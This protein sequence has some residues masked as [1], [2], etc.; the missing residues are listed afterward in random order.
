M[1]G[2]EELKNIGEQVLWEGALPVRF[3]EH[4]KIANYSSRSQIICYCY[5]SAS[6][7]LIGKEALYDK[8]I[9]KKFK[10]NFLIWKL[11]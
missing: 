1:N 7:S 6:R 2:E 4:F 5:Y 10:F 11:H 8:S 3:E 9:H